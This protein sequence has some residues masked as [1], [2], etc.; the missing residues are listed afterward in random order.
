[1]QQQQQQQLHTHLRNTHPLTE[2]THT[3]S[4]CEDEMRK[5]AS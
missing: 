5:E 4:L 1:M 2:E 3:T